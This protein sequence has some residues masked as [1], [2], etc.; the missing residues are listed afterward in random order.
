[1]GFGE[2]EGGRENTTMGEEGQ[3]KSLISLLFGCE[4]KISHVDQG[5]RKDG[6]KEEIQKKPA[7]VSPS[8]ECRRKFRG[9][10]HDAKVRGIKEP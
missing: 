8:Q 10:P 7:E 5:R 9:G 6:E 2:D 4:G 1:M 3:E